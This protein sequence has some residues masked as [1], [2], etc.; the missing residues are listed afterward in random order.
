NARA[1]ERKADDRLARLD[2]LLAD[3]ELEPDEW[4]RTSDA[5]R[6]DLEAAQAALA[7]LRVEE[8]SVKSESDAADAEQRVLDAL[9]QVRAAVAG[10]IAAADE[11]EAAQAAIRR[12]FR[13]F[14]LHSA[15]TH[16]GYSLE[17]VAHEGRVK[18]VAM[19]YDDAGEPVAYIKG[20]E[21]Y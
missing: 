5:N 10:E 20:L 14:V 9:V 11:I 15:W 12:V 2:A 3:G 8:E 4:R 21:T 17:P 16:D 1:V 7:D 6:R 13:H 19:G 18:T